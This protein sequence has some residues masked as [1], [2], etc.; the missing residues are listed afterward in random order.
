MVR[1]ELDWV[2]YLSN[3][4]IS[5]SRPVCSLSGNL[6]ERI[7]LKDSYFI[8]SA[9]EKAKGKK[10][11]YPEYLGD[12]QLFERFGEITGR[13]HRLSK[14]YVQRMNILRRHDWTDNYYIKN[15]EQF[16]PMEQYG[17]HKSCK[18]L[19]NIISGLKKD[20][21]VF[22]L[23]HGDNNIGNFF[24]DRDKITIFDFD[25]CQYSWFIEDIAIQLYYAVYVILDDTIDEREEMA[26]KFMDKFMEGYIIENSIEDDWLSILPLFLKLREII[27]HV[28]MYRS[29]DFNDLN[30]WQRDYIEQSRY[31][32]EKGIPLVNL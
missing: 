12:E 24:L 13:I 4:G 18:E 30:Q 21:E 27:V 1:S 14:S 19:L 8:I 28:G 6:T 25:E 31:R 17:I 15:I 32:I 20:K 16:I 26:K 23:I 2:L 3:N 5:V 11:N 22:G 7:D 9:F 10:L 29:W